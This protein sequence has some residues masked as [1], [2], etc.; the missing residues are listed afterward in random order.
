MRAPACAEPSSSRR[1]Q[2]WSRLLTPAHPAAALPPPCAW[3]SGVRMGITNLLGF[4]RDAL[5]AQGFGLDVTGQNIANASTPGYVK[6]TA[7]LE[8]RAIGTV[9][10]GGVNVVGVG[11]S[12]DRF[13]DA[14]AYEAGSF[15][16]SAH[17]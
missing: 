17:S 15:S 11:R 7:L 14:R 2:P 9:T 13:L 16:S 12:V 10:Y 4:A 6:R 1:V 8:T 5:T 3:T